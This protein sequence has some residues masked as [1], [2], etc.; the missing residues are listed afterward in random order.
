MSEKISRSV[1]P[2][3]A[4]SAQQRKD[5]RRIRKEY[6]PEMVRQQMSQAGIIILVASVGLLIIGV[7]MVFSATAPS[8]IRYAHARGIA[9]SFDTAFKQVIYAVFGL[10]AAGVATFTP[11]AWYRRF[12]DILF[13]FGVGLQALV[14][15]PLGHEVAGNTNWLRFSSSV[16]IQPSE[17]LK[18]AMIVWL[19][20]RLSFG[21]ID[22]RG[23]SLF[24]SSWFPEPLKGKYA[25][26]FLFGIL[27][28]LIVVLLGGDMGTA[29]VFVLVCAG[30][31]WLVGMPVKYFAHL[32]AVG[33]FFV[34]V[35]IS[36]NPSRLNR[37]REYF[38]T[39]L[40]APDGRNPTQA[41]F[42]L[43]A[44]GSGG[45]SGTGPGTSIE[46]WPG[47]L[48]EAQNDFIFA[49]I[50][51]EF[52]LFGCLVVI[53]MF[54]LL[55]FGL[56]KVVRY[57]PD[58]FARVACGGIA[59]WLCGQAMANM[60]VVTGVLP[61]FGVPLPFISQGGSSVIACLLAVG[62]ALSCVLSA[63]GMKITL[64]SPARLARRA[65]VLVKE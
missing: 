2:V 21:L 54:T 35:L 43:W 61:V 60:L 24:L 34:V 7:T 46:K 37:I 45:L 10:V 13:I 4:V 9:T 31:L 29:L 62:V 1:S 64:R 47:N 33:L 59:V 63:P 49:V 5:K 40:A 36:A 8:A 18:L 15:S 65:Q 6:P 39:L 17:F 57:H 50:G 58:R 25:F 55:G 26:P 28:A 41:D 53:T 14:F 16:Q 11:M 32:G 51:E 23:R 56:L 12:A 27:A 38:S 3:K 52:G 42:A 30:I 44:F 22:W 20:S 19:A 48:A